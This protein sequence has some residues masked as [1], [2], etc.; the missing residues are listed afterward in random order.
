MKKQKGNLDTRPMAF[1]SFV[2]KSSTVSASVLSIIVG[3]LIGFIILLIINVYDAG[4]GFI[5]L[6]TG[7]FESNVTITKVFYNAAP[8][9]MCGLAVGFVFKAGLFNI[10]VAGQFLFG[11]FMAIYAGVSWNLPWWMC[12]IVAMIAGALWGA[13]PGIFKA[14]FNVN[15]VITSIMLNWAAVY[16]TR[17]IYY[18]TPNIIDKGHSST[19]S[20]SDVNTSAL[21]PTL[22]LDSL[23]NSLY[24][25]I[26]IIIAILFAVL[27][28]VI[29][30]KTTFGYTIKACGYNKNA[31]TYAGIN[32]KLV[33]IL[34]LVIGGALAG[35][36]GSIYYQATTVQYKTEMS[37][38]VNVVSAIGFNGIP[39]AL[40]AFSN[41]LGIIASSI[42][43]GYL[44]VGGVAM[45]PN[46]SSEMVNIILAVIIYFSAFSLL[47]K[48][49][50]SKG[51]FK[52]KEQLLEAENMD[53]GNT[54]APIEKI[55]K[56]GDKQ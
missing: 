4:Y 19:Y 28:Y 26:G 8:L 7:A 11:G 27:I 48:Q 3:I 47:M 41:P 40:L 17:L 33:I 6:M 36:G 54:K 18:E 32:A 34:T 44:Q 35:I 24:I 49:L 45:Q 53:V 14:F 55:K 25:N 16:L 23:M 2:S 9:L 43:I 51:V 46:Y 5:N 12:M 52:K 50:I 20:L 56:G 22:G 15:E 29:L 21:L 13:I 31:S 30:E 42:F 10:G 37:G 39:V 38:L 1:L